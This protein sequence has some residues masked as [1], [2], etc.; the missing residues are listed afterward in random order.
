[1]GYLFDMRCSTARS[2][3][4]L[5]RM[6]IETKTWQSQRA[7]AH[8]YSPAPVS[9]GTSV[10]RCKGYSVAR[11]NEH[12]HSSPQAIANVLVSHEL[13]TPRKNKQILVRP[14]RCAL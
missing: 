6:P 9:I 7:L 10:H 12:A 13:D 3:C 11:M 14:A 8:K 4:L 2:A 5:R 1:M